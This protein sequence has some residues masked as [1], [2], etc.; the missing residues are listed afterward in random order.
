MPRRILVTGLGSVSALGASVA[1]DAVPAGVMTSLDGGGAASTVACRDTDGRIMSCLFGMTGLS[2]IPATS[3]FRIGSSAMSGLSF[4]TPLSI[5]L[6]RM[7]PTL[8]RVPASSTY[9]PTAP[10]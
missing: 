6:R 8:P 7:R 10:T 9:H 3:A 5:S 2:I 4:M 1:D